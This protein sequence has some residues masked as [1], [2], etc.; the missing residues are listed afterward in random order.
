VILATLIAALGIM[1]DSQ[2]LIIGAM[3]AGPEFGP[4]AGL[5]VALIQ[6]KPGL[7]RRS[8]RALASASA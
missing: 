1:P 8:S 4:L 6:R 2:M 3:V 5:S 7:A